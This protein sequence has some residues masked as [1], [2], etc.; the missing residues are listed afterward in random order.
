MKNSTAARNSAHLIDIIPAGIGK[1]L[2]IREICEYFRLSR[3]ETMAFGDGENDIPMLKE[4]GISI[5]MSIASEKV[6]EK[7]DYITGSS[8]EAGI[9]SALEHFGLI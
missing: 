3:E 4:A 2:G 5:A 1:D 9:T 7:A 8:E 6:R